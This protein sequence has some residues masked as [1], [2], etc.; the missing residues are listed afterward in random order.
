MHSRTDS[1]V[2]S[3]SAR[4]PR[5]P[6]AD[7]RA[8][9]TP[10]ALRR[11]Y[12]RGFRSSSC[13]GVRERR[14]CLAAD[15]RGGLVD[16][17]VVLEGLHHEQG[18]V[19]ASR[20]IALEDGIAHVPAPDGQALTLALLE[21]APAHDGPPRVA[22]K[23]PPHGLHVVVEVGEASQTRERPEHFHDGLELPRIHVLAVSRDVPPA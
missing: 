12:A 16:E 11:Q 5:R 3:D 7:Y 8:A 23:H 10:T 2:G 9:V 6:D 15:D 4:W 18:E 21:V 17:L 19:D 1:R 14:G 13:G 22:A 20:E